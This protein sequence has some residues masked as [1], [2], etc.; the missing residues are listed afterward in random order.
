MN[1]PKPNKPI[2]IDSLDHSEESK[3]L[4][5]SVMNDGRKISPHYV[6]RIW[7]ISEG[8]KERILWLEDISD[9]NSGFRHIKDHAHEFL[10]LEITMDQLSEFVEAATTVGHI[11]KEQSNQLGRN[12]Y[13]FSFH[14]IPVVAGISVS[15]NGFIV[16]M[17]RNSLT[18][19]LEK[20]DFTTQDLS[21]R[22]SWP[23]KD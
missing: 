20:T 16:G 2:D 5:R 4:I 12:V 6:V 8:G 18:T 10:K 21:D 9:K 22:F 7:K 17:N 11:W 14:G 1:T 13:A 3:D 19:F 23:K 15:N